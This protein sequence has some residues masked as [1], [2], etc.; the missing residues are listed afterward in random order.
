MTPKAEDRTLGLLET[1]G[2]EVTEQRHEQREA[3]RA[4]GRLEGTLAGQD[5]ILQS[6]AGDCT[7]NR[8]AWQEQGRVLAEMAPRCARHERRI[9]ELVH[10]IGAS[11]ITGTITIAEKSWRRRMLASAG[12]IVLGVFSAV[13]V[14]ASVAALVAKLHR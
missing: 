9:S 4:L 10:R 12:R 14:A 5:R 8:E 13:G 6:I 7:V 2:N 1:I 11:E 3:A